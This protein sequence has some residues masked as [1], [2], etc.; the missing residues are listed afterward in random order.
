MSE[1]EIFAKVA[2]I[3]AEQTG[4]DA[5]EIT[6]DTKF[7]EDLEADSLDLFQMIN[8]I[9]DAFDVKIAE[10]EGIQTIGDAVRFVEAQKQ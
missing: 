6:M 7:A 10:I 9:E 1:N 8:D 5:G 2:A 4:K 3:A